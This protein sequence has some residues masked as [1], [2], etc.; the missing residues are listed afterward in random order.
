M[1]SARPDAVPRL[2][3]RSVILASPLATGACAASDHRADGP[4]SD[5]CYRRRDCRWPL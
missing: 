4:Y 3:C 1:A 2:V 5:P